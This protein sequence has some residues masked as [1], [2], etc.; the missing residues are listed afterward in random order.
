ME[1]VFVAENNKDINHKPLVTALH[2]WYLN[3]QYWELLLMACETE[4]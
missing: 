2:H 1:V 4:C 3:L